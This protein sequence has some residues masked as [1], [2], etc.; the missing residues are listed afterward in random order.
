MRSASKSGQGG[1][2]S[3][4]FIISSASTPDFLLIVESKAD[5]KDHFSTAIVDVLNGNPVEESSGQYAKRTQRFALDGVLHY[6]E[7]LAKEFNVI[8]LAVSGETKSFLKIS[9]YLHPKR[10]DCAKA[11][12]TKGG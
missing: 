5:T 2:G 12:I 9:T 10:A 3:P 4:E 1:G 11:L 6:A 8:A 7:R